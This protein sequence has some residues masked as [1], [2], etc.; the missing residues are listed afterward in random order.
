MKTILLIRHYNNDITKIARICGG[1]FDALSDG[2]IPKKELEDIMRKEDGESKSTVRRRELL[3]FLRCWRFLRSVAMC[4]CEN[5]GRGVPGR[6]MEPFMVWEPKERQCFITG[7][8]P[9]EQQ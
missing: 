5:T 1:V 8:R 2:K 3:F 9:K 6:I 7:Y 4:Y